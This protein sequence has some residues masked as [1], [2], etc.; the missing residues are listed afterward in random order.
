MCSPA[1]TALPFH[2]DS[3]S[4][5]FERLVRSIN[6]GVG[7]DERLPAIRFH[8]LRQTYATVALVNGENPKV[9][10][11]RLGHSTVGITLD[12][13]SHVLP[14][15]GREA[16]NRIADAILGSVC[17]IREYSAVVAAPPNVCSH[18]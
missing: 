9:V 14:S 8:D 7:A 3:L 4:S 6:A 10:S 2:P 16:A 15:L 18:G 1:R 11:E 5:G 17:V 12:T 13:Y